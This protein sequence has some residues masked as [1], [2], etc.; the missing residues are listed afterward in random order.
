MSEKIFI[1]SSPF[2]SKPPPNT[3]EHYFEMHDT[4]EQ[5]F[6]RRIHLNLAA[7]GYTGETREI[8]ADE[9]NIPVVLTQDEV[10]KHHLHPSLVSQETVV[11]V[12]RVDLAADSE[13]NHDK[14][15]VTVLFFGGGTSE[16][17]GTSINIGNILDSYLSHRE[18]IP[19]RIKSIII[20]PHIAGSPRSLIPK[21]YQQ[22]SGIADAS[23]S[24][25]L[26]APAVI[27]NQALE[28]PEM[29]IKLNGNVI[30]DG[31]VLAGFSAG[32]AQALELASI[33][34]N[35]CTHLLLLDPAGIS[36]EPDL[37]RK[38]VGT[39]KAVYEK[40][41]N[42][43][44]T[45]PDIK[46]ATLRDTLREIRIGWGG[47]HNRLPTYS[48]MLKDFIG[49]GGV[50]THDVARSYGF[51]E[52]KAPIKFNQQLFK[53]DFTAPARVSLNPT[54]KIVV[55]PVLGAGVV[56]FIVSKLGKKYPDVS[57]L[58]YTNPNQLQKD[59]TALLQDMFPAS[60]DVKFSPY[61]GTAHTAVLTDQ[62]Y[63]N[64][65]FNNI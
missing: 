19:F 23:F 63:W 14:P 59:V 65:L 51:S 42:K 2:R 11:R 43:G 6:M 44:R 25:D 57:T 49:L 12:L 17:M 36:D 16:A 61:Y 54:T 18:Q 52:Q 46:K 20:L 8:E 58:M 38:A 35:R 37:I 33:L 4:Q 10:S 21:V 53:K 34:G 5:I 1:S 45:K 7:K 50:W 26:K 40:R 15:L 62:G 31:V 41:N 39:V 9:I 56:N 3:D 29:G 60:P 48:E 24:K 27:L 32:A 22:S 28:A 55:S 30:V 47:P 13:K 64:N